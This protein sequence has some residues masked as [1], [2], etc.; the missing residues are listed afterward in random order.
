[1]NGYSG[2]ALYIFNPLG[3]RRES[4]TISLRYSGCT[5]TS[6][7]TLPLNASRLSLYQ[8]SQHTNALGQLVVNDIFAVQ[9]YRVV[10]H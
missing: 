10:A 9:D 2:N 4:H 8:E 6:C 1:L 3:A 5:T 7:T